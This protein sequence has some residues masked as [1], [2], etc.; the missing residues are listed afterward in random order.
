MKSLARPVFWVEPWPKFVVMP[1]T[2]TPSPTCAGL[3]PAVSPLGAEPLRSTCDSV[4]SKTVVLLLKPTVL[5]LAMLLPATSSLVWWALRPEMAENMERSMRG[6]PRVGVGVQESGVRWPAQGSGGR[7]GHL[8]DAAERDG[9]T[10]DHGLG[11]GLR[12]GA[13]DLDGADRAGLRRAVGVGV[14][15]V[16]PDEGTGAQRALQGQQLGVLRRDLLELLH[17][18]EGR[19]LRHELAAAGR[20]AG[21]LVPHLGDQQLE[22]GVLPHLVG[23]VRRRGGGGGRRADGADRAGHR[24]VSWSDAD[25]HAGGRGLIGGQGDAALTGTVGGGAPRA[26]PGALL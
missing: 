6:A 25:V 9:D 15:D 1:A 11:L 16:V 19:R 3:V 26:R 7:Q 10:A 21:V 5:T 4:S 23:A 22:E 8:G 2:L 17:L 24:A 20:V 14:G 18:G 12:T 13:G